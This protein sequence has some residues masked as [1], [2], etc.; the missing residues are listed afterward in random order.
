MGMEDYDDGDDEDDG[1]VVMIER[2]RANV[3]S[4]AASRLRD[5][6]TRDKS[7]SID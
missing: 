7:G 2:E 6:A 5:K 1:M 4:S 3:E